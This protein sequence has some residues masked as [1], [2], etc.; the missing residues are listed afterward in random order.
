M[1]SSKV[2]TTV[3]KEERITTIIN[4][5]LNTKNFKNK[6]ITIQLQAVPIAC[7]F[8]IFYSHMFCWFVAINLIIIKLNQTS[9][10][11]FFFLEH[12][13]TGCGKWDASYI[14]NAV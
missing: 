11:F 5:L 6:T 4:K 9:Y 3:V 10:I 7:Y 1:N 14:K 8:V 12:T 2:R 13:R